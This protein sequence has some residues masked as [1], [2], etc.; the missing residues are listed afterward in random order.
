LLFAHQPGVR[1]GADAA[2]SRSATRRCGVEPACRRPAHRQGRP[3]PS[4]PGRQPLCR[5]REP[6]AAFPEDHLYRIVDELQAIAGE[7][8]PSVSRVAPNGFL[9]RRTVPRVI[10]GARNEAQLRDN[11]GAAEFRLSPEQVVRL[12]AVSARP[13]IYP[14][15]HQWEV[16][17]DRN[18]PPVT[19]A[20]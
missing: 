2:C 12:D 20:K 19:I 7:T 10:M 8:R 11:L 4:G 3:Q 13:P 17:A 9:S 5:P 14:Y 18:P 16:F 1:V 15:W 6:R